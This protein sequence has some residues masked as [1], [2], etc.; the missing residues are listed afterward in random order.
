M[1][2]ILS[3]LEQVVTCFGI[4]HDGE[5]VKEVFIQDILQS[6][7]TLEEIYMQSTKGGKQ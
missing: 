6:G 2:H 7:T 3:E 4:L 1:S 5:I